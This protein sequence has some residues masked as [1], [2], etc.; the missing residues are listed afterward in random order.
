M[1][2]LYFL[3]G[4]LLDLFSFLEFWNFPIS[5]QVID[6]FSIHFVWHFQFDTYMHFRG[7]INFSQFLWLYIFSQF[8]PL[9]SLEILLDQIPCSF[10]LTAISLNFSYFISLLKKKLDK[11]ILHYPLAL[12]LLLFLIGWFYVEIA[13][14]ISSSLF[15]TTCSCFM[16][17]LPYESLWGYCISV[18]D[19]E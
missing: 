16:D 7:K 18:V 11:L 13:R 19:H 2:T 17:E 6:I 15:V 9:F 1:K 4:S 10:G 5:C 12:L 3:P 14:I 8:F